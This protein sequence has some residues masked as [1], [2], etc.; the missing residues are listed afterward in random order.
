MQRHTV[1]YHFPD[2]VSLF[3]ACTEHGLRMIAPR[4]ETWRA[5]PDAVDRVHHGLGQLYLIYR[6]NARL[7]GNVIRDMTLSPEL[8]EDRGSSSRLNEA[9]FNASRRLAARRAA[10]GPRGGAAPRAR[11][12]DVAIAHEAGAV[13]RRGVRR[14]DI[15]RQGDVGRAV[16]VVSLVRPPPRFRCEVIQSQPTC[17]PS[18]PVGVPVSMRSGSPRQVADA[19]ATVVV[20]V[21]AVRADGVV[22]DGAPQV[23]AVEARAAEL[24]IG[25]VGAAQVGIDE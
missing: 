20:A 4:I 1:Y 11:L 3:K 14:D 21:G 13:R 25:Q 7:L 23:G 18:G 17:Q 15:L 22:E 2:L 16:E 9:Y 8:I 12:R 6:Q 10:S 5:I 19:G 24:G